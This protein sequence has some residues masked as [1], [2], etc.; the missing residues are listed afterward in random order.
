MESEK[1]L[2]T[3]ELLLKELEKLNEI[4][5]RVIASLVKK[6]SIVKNINKE[7]DDERTFGERVADKVAAFGGSWTFIFI[8]LGILISWVVLNSFI[9][10]NRSFDPYPYILLNLFL[11]MIAALQ[12]PIIMMSQ[13]RQA[14]RDRL[15]AAHDYEVN[16]KAE[17][18]IRFLHEKLDDLREQ[19]WLQLVEMQQKQIELLNDI[20]ENKKI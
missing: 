17:L 8:F 9:L 16:M 1:K 3:H 20:L 13:N 4:E 7:A 15:D 2:S 12:A 11:S 14:A 6:R 19:K 10:L 18:E 5:K